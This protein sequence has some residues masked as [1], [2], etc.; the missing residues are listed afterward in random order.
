MVSVIVLDG[1]LKFYYYAGEDEDYFARKTDC[2]SL[3][4]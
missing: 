1:F 2:Q 3:L 4:P